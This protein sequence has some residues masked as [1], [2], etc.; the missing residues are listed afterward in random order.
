M[1]FQTKHH[2][3]PPK[4]IFDENLQKPAA[5]RHICDDESGEWV[6]LGNFVC[7]SREIVRRLL[8]LIT[9]RKDPLKRAIIPFGS[10][11]YL[12][13]A[14]VMAVISGAAAG[15]LSLARCVL[16]RKQLRVANS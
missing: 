15:C 8:P 10:V 9:L 3:Y 14:F 11:L 6:T 7:Q 2:V 12:F 1:L 13:F 5:N 16:L 4:K